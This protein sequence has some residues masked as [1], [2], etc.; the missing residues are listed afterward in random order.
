ME[1]NIKMIVWIERNLCC[2][3]RAFKKNTR[4]IAK[5]S[6]K[7]RNLSLAF[8]LG[9]GFLVLELNDKQKQINKLN[10]KL[11]KIDGESKDEK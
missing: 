3:E 11:S 1:E 6:S 5:N 2:I 4:K 9:F 10:E 8:T 7:I